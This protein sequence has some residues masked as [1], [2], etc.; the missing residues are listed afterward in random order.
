MRGLKKVDMKRGHNKYM[1]FATTRKNRP[2]FY[3]NLE[4]QNIWV[5]GCLVGATLG[6]VQVIQ[7][8]SRHGQTNKCWMIDD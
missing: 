1:D 4:R 8:F 5:G 6:D 3:E 2:G 7:S